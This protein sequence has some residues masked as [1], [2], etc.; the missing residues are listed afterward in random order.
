MEEGGNTRDEAN[1]NSSYFQELEKGDVIAM[2]GYKS[3]MVNPIAGRYC[4]VSIYARSAE[5]HEPSAIRMNTRFVSLTPQSTS[6][7]A[8]RTTRET[9][10]RLFW[11]SRIIKMTLANVIIT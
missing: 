7:Q 6:N 1:T 2:K 9:T 3:R 5:I 10:A 4:L 11:T 8:Q